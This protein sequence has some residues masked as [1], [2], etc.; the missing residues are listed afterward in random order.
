MNT[1][2]RSRR[3]AAR[4]GS[5]GRPRNDDDHTKQCS[6][7]LEEPHVCEWAKIHECGH[8][9]CFT[10]IETWSD[11]ENTCPVCKTRFTLFERVNQNKKRKRSQ[12]STKKKNSKRVQPRDQPKNRLS[13]RVRV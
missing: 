10:C 9:F 6:I 4:S 13:R 5:E 11:Y 12:S 7:C 2:R 3:I 8:E 1:L